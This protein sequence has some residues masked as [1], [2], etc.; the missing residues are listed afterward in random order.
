S[1][2]DLTQPALYLYADQLGLDKA[3]FSQCL[4]SHATLARIREDMADAHALGVDRTPTFFV[5]Q[6]KI[7]QPIDLPQFSQLLDKELAARGGA[8]PGSAKQATFA[9]PSGAPSSSG[10]LLIG[11]GPNIF[12][13]TP[14]SEIACSNDQ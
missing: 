14:G 11:P 2:A 3:R 4:S 13:N 1:Q 7:A 12:A 10:S 6:Q 9:K 8:K 5:G